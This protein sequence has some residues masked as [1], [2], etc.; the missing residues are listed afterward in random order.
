MKNHWHFQA[1]LL[2]AVTVYGIQKI[3]QSTYEPSSRT[4]NQIKNGKYNYY[5]NDI[6]DIVILLQLPKTVMVRLTYKRHLIFFIGEDGGGKEAE[7]KPTEELVVV[8]TNIPVSSTPFGEI[9]LKLP[10][11][12]DESKEEAKG[13]PAFD[14]V[15]VLN[16]LE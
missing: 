1:E 14:E 15:Q 10:V 6:S 5:R 9:Q 16:Y 12:E 3:V 8:L 4:S 2:V 11:K 13:K 7:T